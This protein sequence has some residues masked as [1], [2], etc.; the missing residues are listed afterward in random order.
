MTPRHFGDAGFQ[1]T[2]D[3]ITAQIVGSYGIASA[4]ESLALS[5]AKNRKPLKVPPVERNISHSPYYMGTRDRGTDRRL[6]RSGVSGGCCL[7]FHWPAN[8]A[9]RVEQFDHVSIA[10]L[11]SVHDHIHAATFGVHLFCNWK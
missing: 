11:V 2:L 7:P 4:E 9:L 8:H 10:A 6:R 3:S 1:R 5:G